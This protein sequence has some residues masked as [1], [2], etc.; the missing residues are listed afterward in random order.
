MIYM[1]RW[2]AIL[3]VVLCVLSLAYC[4]PNLIGNDGRAWLAQNMPSW[5]PSK[6]VNL[7]LDLR[8]GSHLQLQVDV[9]SVIRARAED[10]VNQARP[11]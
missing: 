11:E 8:G 3:T 5:L 2:K 10:M 1:S 6:V 9:D 7:G 4:A